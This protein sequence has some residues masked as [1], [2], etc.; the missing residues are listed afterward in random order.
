MGPDEEMPK[1]MTKGELDQFIRDA[2][3]RICAEA[4]DG[5]VPRLTAMFDMED[6]KMAHLQPE[7]PN[8]AA[9]LVPFTPREQILINCAVSYTLAMMLPMDNWVRLMEDQG[10][11]ISVVRADVDNPGDKSDE[12]EGE[13]P[14]GPAHAPGIG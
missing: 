10:F 6:H 2:V 7:N 3:A 4:G 14:I 1:P 11:D 9:D 5:M 13:G 8:A 12:G